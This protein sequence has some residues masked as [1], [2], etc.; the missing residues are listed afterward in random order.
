MSVQG[1]ERPTPVQEKAV[2]HL[3]DGKDVIGLAQTGSGKTGP[4]MM[5][6]VV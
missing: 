4:R 5:Q 3:L 2:P 1:W 6:D